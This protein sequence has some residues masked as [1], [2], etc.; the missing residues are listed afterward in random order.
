M[1]TKIVVPD[2]GESVIEATVAEWLKQEGDPVAVGE[3]VVALETD[4][5]TLEV[6]AEKTASWHASSGSRATM[7]R[8]ERCWG[9][10]KILRR[11]AL[12]T[13]NHSMQRLRPPMLLKSA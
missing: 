8:S 5:V 7:S 4:K 12:P 3:T 11:T 13:V 6:A 10:S 9:S 2:L 1:P